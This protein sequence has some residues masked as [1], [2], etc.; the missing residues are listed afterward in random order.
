MD[1]NTII[2]TI[3]QS[4]IFKDIRI[5]LVLNGPIKEKLKKILPFWMY[6]IIIKVGEKNTL[7]I[8]FIKNIHLYMKLE[9]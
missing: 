5:E 9:L 3:N 7:L 4:I 8:T 2:K 1:I 6:T